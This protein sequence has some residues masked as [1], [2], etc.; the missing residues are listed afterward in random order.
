MNY[1]DY[2]GKGWTYS[3]TKNDRHGP[4]HYTEDYFILDIKKVKD[5]RAKK[6]ENGNIIWD[7]IP[8]KKGKG[9]RTVM[10]MEE[11]DV[12]T[13]LAIKFKMMGS[14]GRYSITNPTAQYSVS[15]KFFEKLK[16]SE[17]ADKHPNDCIKFLFEEGFEKWKKRYSGWKNLFK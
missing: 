1:N 10:R 2:I 13:I 12:T 15:D 6:D 16:R 11:V 4:R 17:Y 5:E 14:S 8:H 3:G 9:F 7:Q